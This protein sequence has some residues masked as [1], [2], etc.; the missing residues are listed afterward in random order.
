MLKL[1]AAIAVLGIAL[2]ACE[3]LPGEPPGPPIHVTEGYDIKQG[4]FDRETTYMPPSPRAWEIH[5]EPGMCWEVTYYDAAGKVLDKTSGDSD[6]AGFEPKGTRRTVMLIF[7]CP[8][9]ARMGSG[10]A[11]SSFGISPEVIGQ[12]VGTFAYVEES[13]YFS[14]TQPMTRRCYEIEALTADAANR[15]GDKLAALGPSELVPAGVAVYGHIDLATD[16]LFVVVRSS[17]PESFSQF[18]ITADGNPVAGLGSANVTQTVGTNGWTTVEAT[19]PASL[20]QED[21][22]VKLV[23]KGA[24][25]AT[26]SSHS[27]TVLSP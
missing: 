2:A 18:D 3:S 16:G 20:F 8:E 11:P 21:V 14:V 6:G 5:P 22:E 23:Q 26:Q 7:P 10:Q 12:A 17:L 19:L 1:F 24:V 9:E 25:D 13:S 4:K 27:M 15:I